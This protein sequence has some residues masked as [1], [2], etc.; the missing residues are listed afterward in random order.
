L[1]DAAAAPSICR[2][3]IAGKMGVSGLDSSAAQGLLFDSDGR[4]KQSNL[5]E[6]ADRIQER[7][8][9][10]SV[11][12]RPEAGCQTSAQ[13]KPRSQQRGIGHDRGLSR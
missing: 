2:L 4:Q 13:G 11:W 3:S 10:R 6:V 7:F 9:G 5:D 8:G 1:D 12:T